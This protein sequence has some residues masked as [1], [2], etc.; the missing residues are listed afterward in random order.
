[1]A[2]RQLTTGGMIVVGTGVAFLIDSFIPWHRTCVDLF[3]TNKICPS[4]NAWGTPF[5]LL[6]TLLVIALVAEVIAVQVFDQK[7][8]AVGSFSWAQIR[9]AAAGAV[10]A[11]VVLQL[12]VGDSPLGRSFGLFLGLVLAAGLLYGTLTRNKETEP[13]AA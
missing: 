3:G 4:E 6:G 5:S 1:M 11:L 2:N 7:L 9:L 13:A 8:P 10:L 12:L